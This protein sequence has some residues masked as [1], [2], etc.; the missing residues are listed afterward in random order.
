[1]AL[2]SVVSSR[3][4]DVGTGSGD[5]EVVKARK[6]AERK[7][8]RGASSSSTMAALAAQDRLNKLAM[9]VSV[10]PGLTAIDRLQ[11]QLAASSGVLSVMERIKAQQVSVA[12][13]VAPL[14]VSQAALRSALAPLSSTIS[15]LQLE[16]AS[17]LNVA[18]LAQA[19]WQADV[20]RLA[21]GPEVGRALRDIAD[22][23]SMTLAMPTADGVARL[24][25]LIGAG[26]IDGDVVD[27]AELSLSNDAELAAAIDR[28]AEVLA[29]SR[30][31]LSRDQA[32]RLVVV[33]VWLMYGAG[34]WALAMFA[35][36]VSAAVGAFGAP[37]APERQ[38]ARQ[39]SA[40]CPIEP[41]APR[42]QSLTSCLRRDVAEAATWGV[43]ALSGLL[44]C[45]R[46]GTARWR[47]R[48]R[49]LACQ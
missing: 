6:D 48:S 43:S 8:S 10:A 46:G 7:L 16:T 19:K 38:R 5:D 18:V 3:L 32:R 20:A 22:L 28:A 30:P 11:K 37:A 35:P 23:A 45:L 39:E 15:R 21:M 24:A 2:L 41:K 44:G 4:G 12:S 26:E 27:E 17:S 34:L 9:Q 36:A 1:M 31:F 49:R 29:A 14:L 13:A 40:S 33:W 42:S 47:A 25:E